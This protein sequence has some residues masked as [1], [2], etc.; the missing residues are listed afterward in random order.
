MSILSPATIAM[1]S[2]PRKQDHPKEQGANHRRKPWRNLMTKILVHFALCAM[3]FALSYSASAQQPGKIFRLG[4]LDN[5]TAS[6]SA[7]RLDAFRQE[8]RELG[9]IELKSITIE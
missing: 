5:S 3:L 4:F 9:W 6:S 2:L 8:L 1:S 7:V